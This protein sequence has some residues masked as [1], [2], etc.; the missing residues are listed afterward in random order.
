MA[1]NINETRGVAGMGEGNCVTCV[2]TY[3]NRENELIVGN[4]TKH[5]SN[6]EFD[7]E[8]CIIIKA[9]TTERI[10]EQEKGM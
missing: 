7:K 8:Y 6:G 3:K 4:P 10:Q 5:I 1:S 9:Y 2:S